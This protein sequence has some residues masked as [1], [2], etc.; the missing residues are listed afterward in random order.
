VVEL[1]GDLRLGEEPRRAP[2][3]V[4]LLDA[5]RLDDDLLA[6][7]APLRAVDDRARLAARAADPRDDVEARRLE[8][9]ADDPLL[10]RLAAEGRVER[11]RLAR[12]RA[13]DVGLGALVA[14]GLE[15]GRGLVGLLLGGG[16]LLRAEEGLARE[17]DGRG[18][19]RRAEERRAVALA[20]LRQIL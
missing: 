8:L 9:A 16:V 11:E 1:R 20:K 15:L 19:V 13:D 2:I 14:R 7:V 6:E 18:R 12:A 10:G 5:H 4:A 17:L 3:G